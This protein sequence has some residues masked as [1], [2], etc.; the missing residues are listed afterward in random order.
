MSYVLVVE[1]DPLGVDNARNFLASF[2]H[3]VHVVP[4]PAAAA[5]LMVWSRPHVVLADRC[6]PPHDDHALQDACDCLT[7][8]LMDLAGAIC[9][10]GRRERQAEHAVAQHPS[11]VG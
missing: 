1:D 6:L 3:R 8:P 4:T 11:P 10:M 7:V 9:L 5:R 2:G